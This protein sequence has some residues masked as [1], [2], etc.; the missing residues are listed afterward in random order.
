MMLWFLA[1]VAVTLAVEWVVASYK[2][3]RAWHSESGY[4]GE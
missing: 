3:Y 1:G 4:W 2:I